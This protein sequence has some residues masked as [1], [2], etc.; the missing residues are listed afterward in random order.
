[1]EMTTVINAPVNQ[2]FSFVNDAKRHHE[3]IPGIV[4]L[5]VTPGKPDRTEEIW[6]MTYAMGPMRSRAKATVVECEENKKI[7]WE[8]SGGMMEGKE[9]QTY[10]SA[11][12]NITRHIYRNEFRLKGLMGILGP[13]MVPMVKRNFRRAASNMKRICETE[14]RIRA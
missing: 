3:W 9:V 8:M 1:M 12:P 14:A 13:L 4:H 10:E 6:T 2:V 7:V 11:G 5:E